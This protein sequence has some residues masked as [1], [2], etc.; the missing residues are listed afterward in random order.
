MTP[1]GTYRHIG[2][3]HIVTIAKPERD[4]VLYL[5]SHKQAKAYAS[6]YGAVIIDGRVV[7]P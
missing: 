2:D 4:L 3:D 1:I 7:L 5:D 6:L